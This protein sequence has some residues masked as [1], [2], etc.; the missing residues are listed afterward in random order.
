[1][2]YLLIAI[3]VVMGCTNEGTKVKLDAAPKVDTVYIHDTI[4][5]RDT[6]YT[7]KNYGNVEKLII[8]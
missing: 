2:K 1:M 8:Y 5:I 3:L 4:Y 7:S 6:I